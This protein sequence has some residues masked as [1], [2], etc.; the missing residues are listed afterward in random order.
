MKRKKNRFL[1]Y[2][3]FWLIV[4]HQ[5]H[6]NSKIRMSEN[7]NTGCTKTT[8]RLKWIALRAQTSV[9]SLIFFRIKNKKRRSPLLPSMHER[10]LFASE[11][12]WGKVDMEL[13]IIRGIVP[14]LEVNT[15]PFNTTGIISILSNLTN[16][17]ARKICSIQSNLVLRKNEQLLKRLFIIIKSAKVILQ[18]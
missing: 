12:F 7:N 14:H 18:S 17:E 13:T 1:Y 4:A 15:S 6:F 8:V 11:S 16:N 2:V 10:D 5:L 9:L 3:V